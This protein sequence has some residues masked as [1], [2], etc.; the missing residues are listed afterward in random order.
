M[1]ATS[2]SSVLTPSATGWKLMWPYATA[3]GTSTS[4]QGTA[5]RAGSGR[6]MVEDEVDRLP[7]EDLPLG[8][9]VEPIRQRVPAVGAA[10]HE[11]AVRRRLH[12][13]RTPRPGRVST[14]AVSLRAAQDRCDQEDPEPHGRG[15]IRRLLVCARTPHQGSEAPT[16][17]HQ[18]GQRITTGGGESSRRVGPAPC[19]APRGSAGWS[20]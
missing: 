17:S 19:R 2:E 11:Y 9:V 5:R 18:N 8:F 10:Q 4:G 20:R 1:A 3:G 12:T 14:S 6:R 13:R 7:A 15:S 16:P